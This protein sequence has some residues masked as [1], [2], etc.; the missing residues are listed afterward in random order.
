M[1][2]SRDTGELQFAVGDMQI[3]ESVSTTLVRS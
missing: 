2:M 1:V 3:N